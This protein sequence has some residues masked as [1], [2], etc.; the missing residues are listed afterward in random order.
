M[1]RRGAASGREQSTLIESIRGELIGANG[2]I[3]WGLGAWLAVCN[4]LGGQAGTLI[5]IRFGSRFL[6]IAFIIVVIALILKTFYEGY[7]A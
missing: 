6:S 7:L 4:F 1:H 5:A 3:L 2:Y